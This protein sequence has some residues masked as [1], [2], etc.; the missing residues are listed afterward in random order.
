M[1]PIQDLVRVLLE[2][3]RW[4]VRSDTRY[5]VPGGYS[6]LD[7]IAVKLNRTLTAPADMVGWST[8]RHPRGR[9]WNTP[10]SG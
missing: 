2:A 8:S 6:D 1:E 9:C 10:N 7:V 3:D 5:Q 4:I